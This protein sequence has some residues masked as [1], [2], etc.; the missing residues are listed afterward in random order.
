MP[1]TIHMQVTLRIPLELYERIE[2]VAKAKGVSINMVIN[3][4]LEQVENT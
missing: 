1:K 2:R 4:M 3:S